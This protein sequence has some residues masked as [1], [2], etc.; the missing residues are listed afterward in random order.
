MFTNFRSYNPDQEWYK[1]YLLRKQEKLLQILKQLWKDH[2]EYQAKF[3][4]T[5]TEIE[6][7]VYQ[8]RSKRSAT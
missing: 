5:E 1:N 6:A 7:E 3:N 2:G 4:Q 8:A